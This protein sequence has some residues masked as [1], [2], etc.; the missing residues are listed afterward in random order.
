MK[1]SEQSK[2]SEV[3]GAASGLWAPPPPKSPSPELHG[4][5]RKCGPSPVLEDS[6]GLAAQ[7][8]ALSVLRAHSSVCSEGTRSQGGHAYEKAVLQSFAQRV[9]VQ[10]R[11]V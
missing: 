8:G 9:R 4:Q 11:P 7:L 5:V 6:W 3:A 10:R 1:S 2:L